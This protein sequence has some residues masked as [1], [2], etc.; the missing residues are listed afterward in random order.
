MIVLIGGEKGGT[1][2]TTIVTNLAVKCKLDNMDVVVIDTDKQGSASSWAA[3]RQIRDIT[4]AI[5]V[6]Q[7]FGNTLHSHVLD[8]AK[9][10]EHVIIDAGGRD[11]VELRSAMTVADKLCIP[12]QPSQFDIWTMAHMNNLVEQARC[13]NRELKAWIVINRAS[14][15]PS[16]NESNEAADILQDFDYLQLYKAGLKDRVA[17]RKAARSGES[18]YEMPKRDEKACGE[19]DSLFNEVWDVKA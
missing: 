14:S 4:P 7:I 16:L 5:S 2:K 19:M 10:Y 18:V 13:V 11:S 12:I 15:N 9:R 3:N 6:V 8:L 1:G 17:F